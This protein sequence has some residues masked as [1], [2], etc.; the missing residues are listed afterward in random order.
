[1]SSLHSVVPEFV[2]KPTAWGTYT[3]LPDT[4]FF[5]CEFRDMTDD[6]PDPHKFGALLSAVHQKSVSPN[7][8]FGFHVTTFA[9]QPAPSS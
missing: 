7:G 3:T 6:M 9:G 2:P 1:M 5:L 8:K 4:H